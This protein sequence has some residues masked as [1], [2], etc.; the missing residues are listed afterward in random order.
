MLGILR[1]VVIREGFLGLVLF[2][3]LAAL[4]VRRGGSVASLAASS[5]SLSARLT[6]SPLCKVRVN[7]YKVRACFCL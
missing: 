6:D 3:F 7:K 1:L 4:R 2:V 5:N